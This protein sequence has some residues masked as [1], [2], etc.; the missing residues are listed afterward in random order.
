MNYHLWPNY[1][2]KWAFLCINQIIVFV[3][4]VTMELYFK[5]VEFCDFYTAYFNLALWNMTNNL[6]MHFQTPMFTC[7][8]WDQM[9]FEEYPEV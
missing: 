8:I 5:Y 3:S 2:F 6:Q 9:L 1:P 4:A 7:L